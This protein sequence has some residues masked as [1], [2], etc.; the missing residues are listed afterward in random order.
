[1]V[2]RFYFIALLSFLLCHCQ[3]NPYRDG[4]RVYKTQCAN[5]HMDSG[6]GL[7]GLIPTLVQSDYLTLHRAQL[8][9]ILRY[10]LHDTITVNGKTYA[11]QMPA[12]AL[13]LDVDIANILNYVNHSWGNNNPP[14]SL[15]EVQQALEKCK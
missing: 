1:M 6:T 14:Y 5:C 10:G 3:P 7:S 11:E 8:P 12:N 4:E 9:C 15:E 13:L 2:H